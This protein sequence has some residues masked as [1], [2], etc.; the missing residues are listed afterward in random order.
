MKTQLIALAFSLA[1]TPAGASVNGAE[2]P[3]L[4]MTPQ[5]A[6][7]ASEP[8]G[9]SENRCGEASRM[10]FILRDPAGGIVAMGVAEVTP[11]CR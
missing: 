11:P 2:A 8:A 6:A 10:F 3:A 5:P 9:R 7:F 1:S 4:D